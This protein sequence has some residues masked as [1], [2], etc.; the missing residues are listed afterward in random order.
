MYTQRGI[1][2]FN[3]RIDA[4]RRELYYPTAIK[5][6]SFAVSVGTDSGSPGVYSDNLTYRVRIPI[7]AETQA[8]RQYLPEKHTGLWLMRMQSGTG[9][10]RMGTSY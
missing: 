9:L 5:D 2:I 8:V 10:C 7:Y 4:D 6:A 3:R 1:T